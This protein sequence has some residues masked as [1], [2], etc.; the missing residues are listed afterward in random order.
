MDP[1]TIIGG[2][3]A[4][5]QLCGTARAVAKVAYRFASN[6]GGASAEVKRF[7][8]QVLLFCDVVEAAELS[9][10]NYC[11]ENEESPLVDFI[12]SR[13]ILDNIGH[14]AEAVEEHL[15]AIH[16]QVRGLGSSSILW[17]SIKWTLK[18]SSIL[19]LVPEMECVKSSL[20]LLAAICQLQRRTC[21][22]QDG[23]KEEM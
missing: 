5:V 7:A 18:K 15:R 13:R 19:G 14:E 4:V 9:L 6:V 2:L 8:I 3:A 12:C 10:R 16:D 11:T 23:S 1:F 22:G 17:A 20:N 21:S